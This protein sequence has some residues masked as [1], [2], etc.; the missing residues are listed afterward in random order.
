MLEEQKWLRASQAGW[1]HAH[2]L[3]Y[4]EAECDAYG[5][6]CWEAAKQGLPAPPL[7]ERITDDRD[8]G[9]AQGGP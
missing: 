9:A 8:Q 6:A 1:D 5:E 7:M 2:N 3:G 4:P